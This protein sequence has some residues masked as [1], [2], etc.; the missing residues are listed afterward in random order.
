MEPIGDEAQKKYLEEIITYLK[1]LP[2]VKITLAFEPDDQFTNAVNQ[3]ISD[4]AGQKVIL[5]VSVNHHIVAGIQMEYQGKFGDYSYEAKT[6]QY[7]KERLASYLAKGVE[8]Q[9]GQ[10]VAEA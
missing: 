5:D 1:T 8:G 7:L 2:V 6:D 9:A 10:K 4:G 3:V